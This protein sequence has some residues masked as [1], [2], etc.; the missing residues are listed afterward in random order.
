MYLGRS[1]TPKG[2][3]EVITKGGKVAKGYERASLHIQAFQSD[4]TGTCH[5]GQPAEDPHESTV[6]P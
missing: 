2:L 4:E 3:G 1:C 5:L 6:V